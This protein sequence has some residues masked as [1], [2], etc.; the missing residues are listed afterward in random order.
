MEVWKLYFIRPNNISTY[1]YKEGDCR[2]FK[3]GVKWN[4]QAKCIQEK[5]VAIRKPEVIYKNKTV[6]KRLSNQ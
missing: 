2:F 5:R 4:F 1:G 6:T 3:D